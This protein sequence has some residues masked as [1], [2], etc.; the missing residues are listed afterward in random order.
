M[1]SELNKLARTSANWDVATGT[2]VNLSGNWNSTYDTVHDLSDLWNG[3]SVAKSSFDL[4]DASGYPDGALVI[5]Y[6]D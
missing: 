4:S 2:V 1:H 6:D 5:V 3:S